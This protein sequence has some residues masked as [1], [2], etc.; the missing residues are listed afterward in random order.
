MLPI[1]WTTHLADDAATDALGA[2]L[3]AAVRAAQAPIAR[4]GLIITLEGPLGSGK[5]A[6][7][8]AL[9]R[10]SGVSGPIKSPTFA[11]LEP[12]V[13]SSLNFYHFDF[14]R[15]SDPRVFSNMG[16]RELIGPGNICAIEWAERVAAYLPMADLKVVLSILDQGRDVQFEA[17]SERG[18]LCLEA[19]RKA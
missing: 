12:Y 16:F 8:R 5:T 13:I 17:Y 18:A 9:L 7:V 2:R 19:I 15:F 10:A 4:E 14:Y 3:A 11:V 6:L 1:T